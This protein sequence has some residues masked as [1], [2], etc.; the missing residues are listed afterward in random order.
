MMKNNFRGQRP[1][2]SGVTAGHHRAAGALSRP[3]WGS[4]P[5][6]P[7]DPTLGLSGLKL[8]ASLRPL[9]RQTTSRSPGH[10]DD[11]HLC[12]SSLTAGPGY[13]SLPQMPHTMIEVWGTQAWWTH[14]LTRSLV[15]LPRWGLATADD[16]SDIFRLYCARS[17]DIFSWM[18]SQPVHSS[19]SC[20]HCLLGLPWC[21][22]PFVIPSR[23]HLNRKND[24]FAQC[25]A[26]HM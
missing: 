12:M 2:R 7:K 25:K 4:L 18:Y 15:D 24:F 3:C 21:R 22:N 13:W 23:F 19:M 10:V 16:H 6:P 14:S 9:W 5:S 8:W 1:S 26:F 20:I 17:C 11:R